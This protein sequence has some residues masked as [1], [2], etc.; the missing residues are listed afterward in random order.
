MQCMPWAWP[1]ED[2]RMSFS[3]E[4]RA[5][6]SHVPHASGT[7]YGGLSL[8]AGFR[9]PAH[10]HEQPNTLFQQVDYCWSWK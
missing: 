5:T 6:Q 1:Q 2:T 10:A 8:Y 4:R 7:L 9:Q 3:S